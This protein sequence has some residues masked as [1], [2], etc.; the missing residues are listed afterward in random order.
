MTTSVRHFLSAPAANDLSYPPILTC[1]EATT[2]ATITTT[3]LSV[4]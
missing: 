1:S 2:I 3:R 4:P